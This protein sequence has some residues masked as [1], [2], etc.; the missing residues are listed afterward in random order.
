VVKTDRKPEKMVRTDREPMGPENG[1]LL[2]LMPDGVSATVA[3]GGVAG[4]V[5][6]V[7]RPVVGEDVAEPKAS[8]PSLRCSPE[9]R[10]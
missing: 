1:R 5:V 2:R 9:L 6:R 10:N 3:L 7:S 4:V 8:L